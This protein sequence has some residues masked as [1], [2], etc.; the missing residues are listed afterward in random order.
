MAS[1]VIR[2]LPEAGCE[3]IALEKPTPDCVRR[4]VCF[5]EAVYGQTK[6][7]EGLTAVLC[8]SVDSVAK[9]ISSGQAPVLI[10]PHA[11]LLGTLRPLALVDARMLKN[12]SDTAIEMAPITIGLGPGFIAGQ[13]CHAA[14]ETNRGTDLGRVYFTGGPQ[15]DTGSPS[16]ICGYA[17]ERVLRSPVTGTFRSCTRI[18]AIVEAGFKCGEV[19]GRAVTSLI[20]GIVRGLIRDGADVVSDQKVGDIDP[21][22]SGENFDKISQKA[23]TIANGVLEALHALRG[24]DG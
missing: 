5:A 2:L 7:I 19:N 21:R 6:T 10:D 1:G 3:V 24:P 17:K 12:Q 20:S 8:P 18:G 13:N 9:I 4:T 22:G 16:P 14:I 11:E 15:A 23:K